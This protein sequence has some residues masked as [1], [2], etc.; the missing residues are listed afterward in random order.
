MRRVSATFAPQSVGES[1]KPTADVFR[2]RLER[3]EKRVDYRRVREK[4]RVGDMGVRR[5]PDHC[6]PS[7]HHG[8]HE[9]L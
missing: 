1:Q 8:D 2:Y 7:A 6:G 4:G 9:G 3:S 5:P